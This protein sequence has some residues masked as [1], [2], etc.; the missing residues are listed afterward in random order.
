MPIEILMPALSP[1]MKE[2]NLAKWLK[3]EGDAVEPGDIIAEIETDKATMEVEAVDDGTI[4]K[5]LV[6]E[7]TEGVAVNTPI[8]VILSEGEE[9]SA[10]VETASKP[11][12]AKEGKENIEEAKSESMQSDNKAV[13][14]QLKAQSNITTNNKTNRLFASPLAKRI[15]E[16]NNIDLSKVL[17]SG[18]RGRII[19][20]DVEKAI[21][22]PE[23]LKPAATSETS[24][25]TFIGQG[26]QDGAIEELKNSSMRKIVAKRLL[27]SKQT[28]P[29]FYLTI[30]CHID[31]LLNLRKDINNR[32]E[33]GKVTVNDMI[34]KASALALQKIPA[35]NTSWTDEHIIQYKDSHISVAVAV[36]GGLVTPVIRHADKKSVAVISKEMKELA[37]KAKQGKLMPEAYQ[38]GTFSI[39]NLGMFGIKEFSAIINPPQSCLLAVG[40]GI[41]KPVI[42]D[43][44][45]KVATVMSCTLSVDHRSVDGAVGAQYL[46]AFKENIED[47]LSLLL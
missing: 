23:A 19:K 45:V 21:Q 7:G 22:S 25:E 35:A 8:A 11:A 36:E 6:Q 34:I 29:H 31:K 1:T 27:E 15:A 24:T 3:K 30:D 44:E 43:G 5:I 16:Q 46:Q 28:I 10:I 26:F 33:D 38:G 13:E 4:G 40:A 32:I 39:S 14:E 42:I 9:A 2:G 12:N 47:P 20:I 41:Q 18:P 37:E 17:G